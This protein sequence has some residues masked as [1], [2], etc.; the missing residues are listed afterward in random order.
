MG[1]PSTARLM[2]PPSMTWPSRS[3]IS[4]RFVEMLN[5]VVHENDR[6]LTSRALKASSTPWFFSVPTLRRTVEYPVSAG[7]LTPS[8][9]SSVFLL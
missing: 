5:E 7:T 4:F 2:N 9:R 1:S 6:A 8:R 3:V